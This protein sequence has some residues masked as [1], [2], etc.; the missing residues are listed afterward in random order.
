MWQLQLRPFQFWFFSQHYRH[1]Q[2]YQLCVQHVCTN[3][4]Q[5]PIQCQ[6]EPCLVCEIIHGEP[7]KE[8]LKFEQCKFFEQSLF[9]EETIYINLQHYLSRTQVSK[10]SQS[11]WSPKSRW[12][13][14]HGYEWRQS[15]TRQIQFSP[16]SILDT[17]HHCHIPPEL[18]PL[19][20]YS[21]D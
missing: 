18:S 6:L 17:E 5:Q 1:G 2:H 3:D 15:R 20:G 7:P 19:V 21:L 16:G 9:V 10:E 4:L 14:N 12:H 8:N 11:T 13:C